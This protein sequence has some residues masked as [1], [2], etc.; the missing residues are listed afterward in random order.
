[1]RSI[2]VH[3]IRHQSH[4][5]FLHGC[6]FIAVTTQA[7]W[8]TQAAEPVAPVDF[9]RQIRPI[10]ADKCFACHGPDSE[11]RQGGPAD[12]EGFRLDNREDAFV[13]LG[14]QRAIVPNNPAESDLV[15]RIFADDESE[16]MP[17]PDEKKQLSEEEKTL[18]KTW[19][20]QGASWQDHWAYTLPKR[21]ATP[22]SKNEIW[23][24]SFI[25]ALIHTRLEKEQIKPSTPADRRVL[26]R[27]IYFDV[28][29]LPPE[30]DEVRRFVANKSPD[31]YEQLVDR[32][33]ESPHFGERMA[34][35]W[36]DLVR[37]ADTVGY[38]GDQDVSIS[39]YR[40]Y[41]IAAFNNNMPFDQFTREQLAG[42]LLNEPSRDQLVASGYNKLGMMSAEG[43]V[44]PKEYLAKYAADRVRNAS[45]VWL[46]STL[47]CAECHDH[48]F[49]PFSTRD[50]YRFASFFADIKERGLYSGA[51]RDGNWGPR[52]DVPGEELPA[53]L[54]PIDKEIAQLENE[55]GRTTPE[56]T[57]AQREW[58]EQAAKSVWQVLKPESPSA[59][60]KTVLKVLNDQSL[61]ATGASPPQ[62]TYSF[63]AKTELKRVTGL[64]VEV[65]PDKS[66][67]QQGPGRAG[68][69]NFVLS[70]LR[71][72][73]RVGAQESRGLALQNPS[74]TIEQSVAGEATPYGK[75]S[76][77]S[78]IDNDVKG[79]S[80]GW[81]I[82]PNSGK[83]NAMV[84]DLAEPVSGD[85][86]TFDITV[87]QNHTNPRHTIGRF[88]ILVTDED[89]PPKAKIESQVPA[90]VRKVLSI[91]RGD[92]DS[93]QQRIADEHFRSVTPILAPVRTRLAAARTRREQTSKTHTRTSLIT[94][95]VEPR[96]MRV[97]HRGDWMDMTGD[98]VEPGV[99]SFLNQIQSDARLTRLDLAEWFTDRSNPLT[100]RVFVN[101]LWKAYFGT[102]LA[103]VLD[104]VGA[105][106]EPPSHPALLDTLAVEFMESGWDVKH[107][108][109]L[110][111]MSHAYRQTSLPRADLVDVDP[112]NR[113]IARQ[114]RFRL[115]AE[116]VRDN[117][118][119][120]SGLLS[121]TIGGRSVKPYQPAGLYRHLNFPARKYQHDEGANQYRRGLYTHWQRQFLHPAMRAFDA[122]SREECTAERPRS[123]TPL[124]ALVLLNDPSYVEAARV[125]A[126][127]AL[128]NED[129]DDS[130]RIDW[131]LQRALSRS[132]NDREAQ[133]LA[134]LLDSQEKFYAAHPEDAKKLLAVG[135]APTVEGVEQSRLAAWTS[136]GRAMLNMHETMSRN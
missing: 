54:E 48:K 55:Y 90:E 123:N 114:S 15:R 18:L 2:T 51:N 64:R 28:T 31:A 89:Q 27:R 129:L 65:I 130:Q 40:D 111:V 87:E 45:T 26:I 23:N 73:L 25:D 117:A 10:L 67:P 17:P 124:A 5:C 79:A 9:S 21:D 110:I 19:I 33:L 52:V 85:N 104:D 30:P 134:V 136:I 99:P 84:V 97:L 116:L 22:R 102:G 49:D 38:H 126:Q 115:D 98:I 1:M 112:Y 83:P 66:L 127:A 133:V 53:L 6:F 118:L 44:Q 105:Q 82:L 43:G 107:I 125:F 76:A 39:P 74:A 95:A 86:L 4:R 8:S 132:A 131:M 93:E 71:V 41:V 47:G 108:V 109:K 7:V 50:F 59:L 88:R 29:G 78:A 63:T 58:E 77:A 24:K 119:S 46:G 62:N 70:E 11:Q 3:K 60:H 68:N 16:V 32:L 36:L 37:Y 42:D 94:V 56:L 20:E 12:S 61:L 100:A 135:Q 14:G 113:L 13:D 80:W 81:A 75:W 103:K 72:K 35:S 120:I 92:R 91:A 122:P 101:R 69:G 106:G 57:S 34:M 121:P 128:Q 96:E